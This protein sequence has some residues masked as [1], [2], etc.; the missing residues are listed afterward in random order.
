MM[1]CAGCASRIKRPSSSVTSMVCAADAVEAKAEAGSMPPVAHIT[2]T[3]ASAQ[4]RL[5]RQVKVDTPNTLSR[6][7]LAIA[8]RSIVDAF[9]NPH[10]GIEGMF[11]IINFTDSV[12]KLDQTRAGL[13]AGDNDMLLGGAVAQR[14]QHPLGV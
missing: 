1:R 10:T 14:V 3:I 12:C 5:V 7:S 4:H 2:I 13:A 11:D 6:A 9:L 8:P